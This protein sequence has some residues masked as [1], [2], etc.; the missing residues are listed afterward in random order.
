VVKDYNG[1]TYWL[2]ANISDFLPPGNRF[3]EW[4]CVSFGYSGEGMLGAKSNPS[5]YNGEPLPEFERYPQFILSL[6]ADLTRIKT[7]NKTVRLL[8]NLVGYIKIPFPAIEFNRIDK[9]KGHWI[10][11]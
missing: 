8:L 11:F 7:N 9:I 10:Y 3:P 5:E 1:Q 4:L 2:S 6:D